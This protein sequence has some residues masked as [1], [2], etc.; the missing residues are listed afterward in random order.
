MSDPHDS[1][2]SNLIRTLTTEDPINNMEK[3][4]NQ[5]NISK[6]ENHGRNSFSA[7][8]FYQNNAERRVLMLYTGGTIGMI[9]NE[10][11]GM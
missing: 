4:C 5:D 3:K 11:G 2:S 6:S 7:K 1:I 8:L 9:R 10:N